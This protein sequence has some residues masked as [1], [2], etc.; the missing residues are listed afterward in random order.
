MTCKRIDRIKGAKTIIKQKDLRAI[1][2]QEFS[3]FM[4]EFLT[5]GT[6]TSLREPKRPKKAELEARYS[7]VK[8]SSIYNFIKVG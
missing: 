4:A 8:A 3:N 7:I 6:K 5:K 1:M 2:G